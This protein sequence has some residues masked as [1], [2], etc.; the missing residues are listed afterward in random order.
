M[1]TGNNSNPVW[2]VVGNIVAERP[3]GTNG[4]E[5]KQGTKAFKPGNKVYIIDWYPGMCESITVI[6]LARKSKKLVTMVINV[7]W[8]ENLRIKLTYNPAVIRK[9]HEY[10][11]INQ[12]YLTEEFAEKLYQAIPLWQAALKKENE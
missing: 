9:I 10:H 12:T 5:T 8:V 1:E 2:T 11:G 3:Y 6:G 4:A 7:K